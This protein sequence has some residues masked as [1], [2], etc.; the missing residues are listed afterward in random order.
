MIQTSQV[1]VNIMFHG[2]GFQSLKRSVQQELGIEL[3]DMVISWR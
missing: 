2:N 3:I 1:L